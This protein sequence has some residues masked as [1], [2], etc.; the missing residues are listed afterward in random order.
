MH[1]T[2]GHV[3]RQ[4]LRAGSSTTA[5]AAA[6]AGTHAAAGDVSP[7]AMTAGPAPA[8]E[9][10]TATSGSATTAGTGVPTTAAA[11]A[12]AT[13]STPRSGVVVRSV[14]PSLGRSVGVQPVHVDVLTQHAPRGVHH[15]DRVSWHGF[16][17]GEGVGS[18]PSHGHRNTVW[19]AVFMCS[20]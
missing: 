12:A 16:A 8:V 4:A 5:G 7:A 13:E 14:S 6:T 11:G 9:A 1:I 20:K 18:G 10:A 2:G 15:V 17:V 3:Y 19:R